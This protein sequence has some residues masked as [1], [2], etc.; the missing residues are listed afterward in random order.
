MRKIS[1]YDTLYTDFQSKVGKINYDFHIRN[2]GTLE[3]L[4]SIAQTFVKNFRQRENC[5]EER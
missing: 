2:D 4:D 5:D 1:F 3:D